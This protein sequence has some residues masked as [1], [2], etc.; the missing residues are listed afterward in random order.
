MTKP[1]YSDEGFSFE[2]DQQFDQAFGGCMRMP[3]VT[4]GVLTPVRL[5]ALSGI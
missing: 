4:S 3:G 1:G 5:Q 2:Q